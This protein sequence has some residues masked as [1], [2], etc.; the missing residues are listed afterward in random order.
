MRT[1]QIDC[2]VLTAFESEF[3]FLRNVFGFAGFRIYH[4]DTLEEAEF[5]LITTGA[6]VLLTD[7][8]AVD[9]SWRTAL[10]ALADR[11]PLVAA[12]VIADSVDRPHL[13]DAFRRGACGIVWKPIQFDVVTDL[14]RAAHQASVDRR[15]LRDRSGVA[16]CH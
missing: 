4:A 15:S 14:I 7:I 13:A 5:L 8:T 2:V 1:N 16:A 12:I 10:E 6:T 11:H 3:T 9:C